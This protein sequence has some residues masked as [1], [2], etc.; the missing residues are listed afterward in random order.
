MLTQIRVPIIADAGPRLS[1][2]RWF[3]RGGDPIAFGEPLV[4]ID[5]DNITHEV[6]SPVT[7]VRSKIVVK[8]GGSVEAGALLGIISQC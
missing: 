1:L 5:T 4:E 7:E 3:K 6:R 2:G 8:D